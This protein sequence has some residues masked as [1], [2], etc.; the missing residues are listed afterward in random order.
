MKKLSLLA[1]ALLLRACGGGSRR[2]PTPLPP[3]PPVDPAPA[4]DPF[5]ARVSAVVG[6]A[7]EDAQAADLGAILG[8]QAENTEPAPI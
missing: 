5:F 8:N 1:L 2:E 3:A 7:P 4:V 6:A